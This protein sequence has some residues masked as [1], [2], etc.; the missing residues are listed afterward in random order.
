[1]GGGE[2]ERERE[3]EPPK[4]LLYSGKREIK[5]KMKIKQNLPKDN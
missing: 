1:V 4:R 2:R 5:K 3:A